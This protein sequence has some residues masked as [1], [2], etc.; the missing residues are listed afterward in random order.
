MSRCRYLPCAPVAL[1]KRSTLPVSDICSFVAGC[2]CRSAVD[3]SSGCPWEK[4]YALLAM[5]A[6]YRVYSNPSAYRSALTSCVICLST[7]FKFVHQSYLSLSFLGGVLLGAYA[8][9]CLVYAICELNIALPWPSKRLLPSSWRILRSGTGAAGCRLYHSGHT[10][11]RTKQTGALSMQA[12]LVTLSPII[13]AHIQI[14]C[15]ATVLTVPMYLHTSV[16]RLSRC[17]AHRDVLH[18]ATLHAPLCQT[19][20]LCVGTD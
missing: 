16:Q 20:V 13:H 17:L 15:A 12:A 5:L 18:C 19:R 7:P 1:R 14:L 9:E 10:A 3:A 6:V 4:G 2:F 8:A 11:V